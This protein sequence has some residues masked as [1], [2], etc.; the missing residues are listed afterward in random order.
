MILIFQFAL[1]FYFNNKFGT[2]FVDTVGSHQKVIEPPGK[3]L[4]DNIFANRQ[5]EASALATKMGFQFSPS[6]NFPK[7]NQNLPKINKNLFQ[8]LLF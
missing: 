2:F 1:C 3:N 6:Y 8:I 7:L 5:A 4:L